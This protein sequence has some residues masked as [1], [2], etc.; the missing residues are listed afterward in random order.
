MLNFVKDK[1]INSP[2]CQLDSA[3]IVM[4]VAFG[5]DS[6]QNEKTKARFQTTKK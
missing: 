3:V 4:L 5:N 6:E 1:V 2:R